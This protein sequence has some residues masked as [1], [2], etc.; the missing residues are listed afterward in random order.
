MSALTDFV[1][2]LSFGDLPLDVQVHA[3]RCLRDLTG[4]AIAGSTTDLSRIVRDHAARHFAA[5]D[6]G[7]TLWLDGRQVSPIGAALAGGMT[8][9]SIDAHDGHRITKGHA[10]CG[11][12]PTAVALCEAHGIDSAEELLAMLVLGYE[13]GTRAGITLHAT[14]ADYHTSGAWVALA[15][16]AI[17]ARALE[18][19]ETQTREALGIAEY[20]GPRSQMMRAID[21]PTMVKDGSGWGAMAGLSAA[22]L[23]ADGFTGAPALT[24]EAPDVADLWA[25]LG[26]KWHIMDQYFKPYP[27]CRWAQPAVTAVLGL[28]AEHD[29]E[30]DDVASIDIATF[31]E[32]RRLATALPTTTEEAQYSLPW[33]VAAAVVRGTVGVEEI[34]AS[35]LADPAIIRLADA[36]TVTERDEFN[37]AFPARRFA[38]VAMTLSDGTIVRSAPTEPTGDPETA[39]TAAEITDKFDRF[40]TPVLGHDRSTELSRCLDGFAA[41]G[42]VKQY[43][44]LLRD[45]A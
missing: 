3:E 4:V 11:V 7:A 39:L 22:Y 26:S 21:H 37:D 9:D 18:S 32:A 5:S 34:S 25:D 27:V 1:H 2:D 41:D 15:C 42:S 10:G 38:Q 45:P 23:A 14:V 44:D 16:A 35:A 17:G 12:L 40:T 6:I 31:H 19:D 13:I 20:H 8:I 43:V 36:T 30:S 24:V 29:L 33:P 28:M